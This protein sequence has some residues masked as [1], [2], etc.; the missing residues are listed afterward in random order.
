MVE[1]PQTHTP[2]TGRTK[3]RRDD[4]RL[5][6]LFVLWG[7]LGVY[8]VIWVSFFWE[9]WT[10]SSNSAVDPSPKAIY[11][12]S[13]LGG[14]LGTSFAVALGVQ[15]EDANEDVSQMRLGNTLVGPSAGKSTTGQRE[16]GAAQSNEESANSRTPTP[17]SIA[18]AALFAYAAVGFAALA[19]VLFRSAQS[20]EVVESLA[21]VFTGL[22]IA[23]FGTAF[24]PG[25]ERA[26]P[27]AATAWRQPVSA[28]THGFRK[29]FEGV[30]REV[31]RGYVVWGVAGLAVAVPELWA[32]FGDPPWPTISGTV[33][34]LETRWS[35][36]AVVTVV[37]IVVLALNAVRLYAPAT[38][39]VQVDQNVD[40]PALADMTSAAQ[41]TQ[42]DGL[43]LGLTSAGWVK[44]R[45]QGET[46]PKPAHWPIFYFAGA[47]GIV[48]LGCVLG[49]TLT[50]NEWIL[51]YV[52]YSLIAVLCFIIPS[53]LAY[54]HS[55]PNPPFSSLFATVFDLQ[56]RLHWIT[57][58]LVAGL[59]VLLI[60]L[61]LYPWPD[62]FVP[63]PTPQSP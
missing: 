41:A 16:A 50:D 25:Q 46:S 1:S 54:F 44:A 58:L 8:V 55:T 22:V 42:T 15:R 38:V 56:G 21:V 4:A 35:G 3:S 23:L 48:I 29:R 45:R 28:L 51:G 49:T 6:R 36:T 27:A 60:H 39:A 19:T 63:P 40:Q 33:G 18:T 57:L 52:I 53:T 43:V 13:V 5:L 30:K 12:V 11:I 62:I 9:I 31:V 2:R 37:V 17:E 10:A 61:A 24:L 32:A 34:H 14:V 7:A 59:V 20:P 47:I 26:V